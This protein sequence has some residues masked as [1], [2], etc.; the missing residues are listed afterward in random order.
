[1]INEINALIKSPYI[2][3]VPPNEKYKEESLPFPLMMV[4][5]GVKK[6][7][8][9]DDTTELKAAPITTPTARST[10]LPRKIN[11]LNPSIGVTITQKN[12]L[13]NPA[14]G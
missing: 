5:I 6:L 13:I 9:N 14:K 2:I 4:M 1:M 12:K 7:L 10:T 11:F 8:T 3:F